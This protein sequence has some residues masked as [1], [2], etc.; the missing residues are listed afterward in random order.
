MMTESQKRELVRQAKFELARRDLFFYCQLKAPDFYKQDRKYQEM[1]CNSLQDFLTDRDHDVLVI[2]APP[3]HG[4]SRTAQLAV[5]WIL[6]RN[7]DIKIMTG[8]YNELLATQFSKGV[9]NSI[10]EEK[11]DK[12]KL[13]YSDIFPGTVIKRGD[14]AMNLW[15]LEDGFNNYLAT[16]P[17]G[18]ATGFGADLIIID[19]LIKSAYEANNAITLDEHWSWFTNT[20]LSRL[21]SGGKIIIIMTRWH[22]KDLAGRVMEELPQSG[23][24]VKNLSF[25]AL[26]DDGHMLCPEVLSK[27][28]Y[29][30]KISTM[31]QD[32]ASANYQQEPIDIKGRLYSGF[33]TYKELPRDDRGNLVFNRIGLYCDTADTGDDYLCSIVYGEIGKEAYIL[34]VLYTKEPMEV[35]E[36]LVAMMCV[37]NEVSRAWIESNN[38]GRGFARAVKRI[39]SGVKT[40]KTVVK[41]FHQSKNKQSRIYTMAPYVM[42]HLY[43]PHNWKIRWPEFYKSMYEYQR[44]GKNLH[45]DAQDAITGV[46]ERVGQEDMFSF[47]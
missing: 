25:K 34:D 26:Q 18:T 1:L 22:S 36:N 11:A 38:G 17:K 20:M 16:S 4:K 32:I 9:R 37:D 31:G 12:T 42:E 8:S 30:K 21:E 44:E 47:K 39:L 28:E 35:T 46:A 40:N 41:W 10:Q 6:G 2:N 24:S 13:I 14:G 27:A 3:R 33:K 23:Y 43:F 15:S 29:L 19:D 5:E 7:H 45:D